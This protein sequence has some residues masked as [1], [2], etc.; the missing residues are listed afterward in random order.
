MDFVLQLRKDAAKSRRQYAF[1]TAR[2]DNK[3]FARLR[4]EITT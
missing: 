1:G 2:L 3:V 4:H